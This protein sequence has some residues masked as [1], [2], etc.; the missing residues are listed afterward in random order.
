MVL[1]PDAFR[2]AQ[3]EVDQV[4]GNDRLVDF[5]DR[6]SLPYFNSILKEVLR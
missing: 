6:N 3:E 5:D 2:K 1:H 4:I